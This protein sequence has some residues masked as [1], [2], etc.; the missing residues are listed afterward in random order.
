MRR[1]IILALLLSSL[2][3]ISAASNTGND[4]AEM[5]ISDR[6]VCKIFIIG[7]VR[8]IESTSL[9][10]SKMNEEKPFFCIPPRV[11]NGQL[12]E[13]VIKYIK[14]NPKD[15]HKPASFLSTDAIETAYPCN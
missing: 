6:T 4:L 2:S 15:L 13:I 12:A 8:G 1:K 11:T 7:M 9:I 10:Y 14:D 5:C 3:K